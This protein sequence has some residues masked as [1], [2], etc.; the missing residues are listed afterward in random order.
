[1]D[2]GHM[3]SAEP[4]RPRS[5]PWRLTSLFPP[6]N[7]GPSGE[8]NVASNLLDLSLRALT[9]TRLSVCKISI[10][11]RLLLWYKGCLSAC[12]TNLSGGFDENVGN[13]AGNHHRLLSDLPR[14]HD[15]TSLVTQQ[16]R[17]SSVSFYFY[18]HFGRSSAAYIHN[19]SIR[20]KGG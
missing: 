18:T 3:P 10:T 16:G 1:M 20:S 7:L 4:N 17:T 2:P 5:I 13:W 8:N 6:F 11:V 14:I 15:G 9:R 19:P 12:D